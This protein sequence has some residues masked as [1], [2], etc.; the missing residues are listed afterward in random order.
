MHLT[1]TR[2][3]NI[4]GRLGVPKSMVQNWI[5]SGRT[6][7]KVR[8]GRPKIITERE[9]RHIKRLIKTNRETH[10]LSAVA[11]IEKL[12]LKVSEPTLIKALAELNNFHCIAHHRPYLTEKDRKRQLEHAKKFKDWT[13]DDFK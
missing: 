13:I 11:I 10:R 4:V 6:H 5:K 1:G 3:K 8:P 2:V 9:K 12:N 7:V